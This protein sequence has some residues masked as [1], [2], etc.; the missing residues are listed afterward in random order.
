MNGKIIK[1]RSVAFR[2]LAIKSKFKSILIIF[3]KFLN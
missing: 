1:L 2:K 3:I